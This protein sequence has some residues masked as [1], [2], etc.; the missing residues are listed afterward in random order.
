MEP[1]LQ[2]Q[3]FWKQQ[4]HNICKQC[5]KFRCSTIF[6]LLPILKYFLLNF[7]PKQVGQIF[8]FSKYHVPSACQQCWLPFLLRSVNCELP[9][10]FLGKTMEFFSHFFL[11]N[12][13]FKIVFLL[14]LPY[15]SLGT[16]SIFLFNPQLECFYIFNVMS[17]VTGN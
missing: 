11:Y 2:Q 15:Q 10:L 7:Q 4:Q 16:L 9:Q 1:P 6:N 12:F 14:Q 13:E 3:F 17:V 5:Q 8:F